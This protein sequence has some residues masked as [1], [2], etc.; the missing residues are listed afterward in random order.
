[1]SKP[2]HIGLVGAG[3]IGAQHL[4]ALSMLADVKVV[5]VAGKQTSQ[6]EE[7]AARYGI[8]HV[9]AELSEMLSL[10]E[11]DAIILCTPTPL[12]ARQAVQCLE[13]G[14]HV[15]V[16][17]PLADSLVGAEAVLRSQQGSGLVAM[18]A[19]TRRFNS[20][21]RWLHERIDR[22][23]FVLRQL[24]VQTHFLRRHN[25]NALGQPRNWTD[26]LLWHHAA[27]TVDLFEY[28]TGERVQTAHALQG[29]VHPELGLALDMSIQLRTRSG[30]LC[31]LSLSFNN[32][33]PYGSTFRYIGDGET[34]VAR[35]D[36]LVDGFGASI[37]LPDSLLGGIAAQDQEFFAAIREKREPNASVAS[38][39]PCYRLLDELE[40]QLI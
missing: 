23:A 21:H 15:L 25:T 11:V 17:I 13:S 27:H 14:R 22:G 24:D 26:H 8:E 6:V 31:T 39:L 19:H 5:S 1:M 9:C 3:A 18:C 33:G 28:Q 38:V 20:G 7:L 37:D 32:Q 16:E 36:E 12:H 35:Y 4:D 29:P 30:A 34:F 2:L 40:R 10:R